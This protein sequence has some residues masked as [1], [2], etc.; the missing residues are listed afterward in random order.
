MRAPGKHHKHKGDT[1]VLDFGFESKV[2]RS[3]FTIP[4]SRCWAQF[5]ALIVLGTLWNRCKRDIEVVGQKMWCD[6]ALDD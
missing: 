2:C 3:L 5:S 1:S 4:L 6:T